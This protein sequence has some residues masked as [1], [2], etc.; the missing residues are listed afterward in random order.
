MFGSFVVCLPV[1][2]CCCF[3]FCVFVFR[4]VAVFRCVGRVWGVFVFWCF[5]VSVRFVCFC[6]LVRVCVCLFGLSV[7]PHDVS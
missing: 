1:F 5:C 2:V 6:V 7:R 3:S 4:R